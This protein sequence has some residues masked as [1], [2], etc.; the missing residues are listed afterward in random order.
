MVMAIILTLSLLD[1][2]CFIKVREQIPG[3]P[4]WPFLPGGGILAYIK[5]YIPT[6]EDLN[7]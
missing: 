3:E 4:V 5:Y 1:V 6:D 7:V 2:V